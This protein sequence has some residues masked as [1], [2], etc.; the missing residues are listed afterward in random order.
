M[1]DW[2]AKPESKDQWLNG[3]DSTD[4][5]KDERDVYIKYKNWAYE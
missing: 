4:K 1:L 3:F 5:E 2:L